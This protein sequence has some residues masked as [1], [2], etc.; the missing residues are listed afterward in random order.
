MANCAQNIA[1]RKDV[2]GRQELFVESQRA[3][4]VHM[5][6]AYLEPLGPVMGQKVLDRCQRDLQDLGIKL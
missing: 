3:R 4:R 1:P 5:L 6:N 2:F